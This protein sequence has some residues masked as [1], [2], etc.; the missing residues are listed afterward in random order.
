[1]RDKFHSILISLVLI[2][3][4]CPGFGDEVGAL[5]EV[6]ERPTWDEHVGP[7]MDRYCNECHGVPAQQSAPGFFRLDQC[8]DGDILGAESQA[9]RSALRAFT[10]KDM[11]PASY[12]P[13]PSQIEREV[14]QQWVDTGSPCEGEGMLPGSDPDAG[15]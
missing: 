13:Q 3:L 15:M 14:L 7:I 4:G 1:M 8:E 11:P 12:A 5:E 10:I 9:A 2:S 6:P